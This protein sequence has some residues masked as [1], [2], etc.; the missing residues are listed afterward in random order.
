MEKMLKEL[1]QLVD[2]EVLGD[3]EVKILG[4]APIEE[5]RRG[6]I[7]FVGHAKYL[8]KLNETEASAGLCQNPS[9]LRSSTL[10]TKGS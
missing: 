4:V 5:A 1:A 6:E 8:S 3:G 7:T 10:R 9:G 2:G